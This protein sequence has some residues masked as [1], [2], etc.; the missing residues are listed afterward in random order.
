MAQ[1][2]GIGEHEKQDALL[3][4]LEERWK[5]LSN[6]IR[7]GDK[8]LPTL[9]GTL[10]GSKVM[11]TYHFHRNCATHYSYNRYNSNPCDDVSYNSRA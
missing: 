5:I 4:L 2:E 9:Q 11:R 6:R 1:E 10:R 3:T 7:A 8:Q